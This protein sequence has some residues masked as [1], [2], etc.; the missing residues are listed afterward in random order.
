VPTGKAVLHKVRVVKDAGRRAC[1][2]NVP[3]EGALIRGRARASG[4]E[5]FEVSV[6]QT[7]E[8]VIDIIRIFKLS[9]NFTA[10]VDAVATV[11]WFSPAPRPA[12][13]ASN[14]MNLPSA[15]RMKA[16]GTTLASV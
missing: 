13:G 16:C 9:R 7:N 15:F 1:S 10:V 11:P 8:P 2:I 6:R 12:P 4:V 3:S 5:G 14:E